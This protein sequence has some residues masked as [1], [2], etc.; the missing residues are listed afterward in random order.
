MQSNVFFWPQGNT[1]IIY[2]LRP[3][4]HITV[5]EVVDCAAELNVYLQNFYNWGYPVIPPVSDCPQPVFDPN[6]FFDG[7]TGH[8]WV[9]LAYTGEKCTGTTVYY[10]K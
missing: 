7:S 2:Y 6:Y 1:Q 4:N 9:C 3:S 8:D 5:G 10:V